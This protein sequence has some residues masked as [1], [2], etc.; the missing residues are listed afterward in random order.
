[1]IMIDDDDDVTLRLFLYIFSFLGFLVPFPSSS[2]TLYH[3]SCFLDNLC[4]LLN[5]NQMKEA[6]YSACMHCNSP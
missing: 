1:M 6:V 2:Y 4:I 5:Y 3:F